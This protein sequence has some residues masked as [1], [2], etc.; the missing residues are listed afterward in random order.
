MWQSFCGNL[1]WFNEGVQWFNEGPRLA[2]SVQR[3]NEGRTL[4]N[5]YVGIR[6]TRW[7]RELNAKFPVGPEGRLNAYN[8]PAASRRR[9]GG[10]MMAGHDGM[11]A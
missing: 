3:F 2:R 9:R 5:I 7:T 1:Q 4:L 11:M 8:A 6:L 10:G